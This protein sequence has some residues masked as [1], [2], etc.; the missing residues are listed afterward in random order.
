VERPDF[1]EIRRRFYAEARLHFRYIWENFD[2]H[3]KSAV[4]RVAK[5]RSVPDALQHV[6]QELGTRHY[7]EASAEKPQ[8]F[9]QTFEQFVKNEAN[10]AGKHSLLSRLLNRD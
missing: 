2:D 10:P 4:L 6:L 8:L 3:E 5:G 7:V 1:A 9:A